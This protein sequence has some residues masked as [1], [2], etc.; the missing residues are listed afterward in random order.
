MGR[1]S[2]SQAESNRTRIVE[3]ASG[4][5]RA[6]GVEAISIADV[7]KAAGM[8]QGGFYRHFESKDGLAVEACAMA[9]AKAAENWRRIAEGAVR[10]GGDA[11]STIMAYYLSPKPAELTCP[12]IALAADVSQH[13]TDAPLRQA[14]G[15][16]VQRLFEIFAGKEGVKAQGGEMEALFASM[17][18]AAL[19]A[20]AAPNGTKFG[21]PV[22]PMAG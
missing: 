9:F 4:L 18:G 12:M 17:V 10:E 6:R 7:M 15:D 16:G 3:A 22:L 2:R 14:Y 1:S 20:R 11:T 13:A 5:F 8:T 19:L 21:E